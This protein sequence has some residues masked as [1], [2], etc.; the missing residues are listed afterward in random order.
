M[1]ASGTDTLGGVGMQLSEP[2]PAGL[3]FVAASEH[4]F[5]KTVRKAHSRLFSG[6]FGRD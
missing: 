3:H 4:L 5:P 2:S 6:Y 1:L